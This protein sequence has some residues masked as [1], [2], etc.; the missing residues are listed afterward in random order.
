VD[1]QQLINSIIQLITIVVLT[2]A[3]V[4]VVLGIIT[5]WLERKRQRVLGIAL[6]AVGLTVGIGY[7]FLGSRFAH[8]L[9]GDL[10]V[11]VDLPA[12]MV[13]AFV[14]TIGVL[15]GAGVAVGLFLWATGRFR[16]VSQT[17]VAV[18]AASAAVA[19]IATGIAIVLST[20]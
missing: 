19:L 3:L 4:L 11:E 10:I 9:F 6:A 14:Y 1:Q 20:P 17:T 2:F 13:T 5:L 16:E 15:V 18:V 12:L 8:M 7:A